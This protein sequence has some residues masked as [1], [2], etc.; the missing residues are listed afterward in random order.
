MPTTRTS[1]L[2]IVLCLLAASSAHAQERRWFYDLSAFQYEQFDGVQL[3]GGAIDLG[4]DFNNWLSLQG[5]LGRSSSSELTPGVHYRID[6]HTG[7]YLRG[8]VRYR[9]V[10]LYALGG[11]AYFAQKG[12]PGIDSN[13]H[14]PALGGGIALFGT[15]DTA[16]T[17]EYVRY[18]LS[19]SNDDASSI[20]IGV[21]HHFDWERPVKRY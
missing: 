14:G 8:N 19:G 6:Y 20:H 4:Y 5:R 13:V 18:F 9:Q 21:L 2:C 12:S 3:L 10:T 15:E 7:A 11:Y 17:F 1:L 16:L